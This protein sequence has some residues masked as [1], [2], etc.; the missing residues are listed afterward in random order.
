MVTLRTMGM[1]RDMT[2]AA[3]AAPFTVNNTDHALCVVE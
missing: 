1:T 3:P 2:V